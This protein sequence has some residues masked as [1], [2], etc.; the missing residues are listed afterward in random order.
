MS[1]SDNRIRGRMRLRVSDAAGRVVA[2]RRADNLVLRQ[3]ANI[4]ADLFA[5][6]ADARPINRVQVG[7]GREAADAQATA[8]TPSPDGVPP[9]AL[10]GPVTPDAFT[11]KT[12]KPG[13]VQVSVVTVFRPTTDLKEV[14]EAGLMADERLYNHVVFEPLTLRE[15]QDITFFWEVD[16]PYGH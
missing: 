13:V 14:T 9:D 7:F 10:R 3:G 4:V 8:L 12:D 2:E 6:K 1:K 5:G 15:G 16:F 11:I